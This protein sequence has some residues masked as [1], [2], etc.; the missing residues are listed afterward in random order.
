[1]AV[2]F[3]DFILCFQDW[4]SVSCTLWIAEKEEEERMRGGCQDQSEAETQDYIIDTVFI[5]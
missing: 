2:T 3:E 1:M 4:S 5:N